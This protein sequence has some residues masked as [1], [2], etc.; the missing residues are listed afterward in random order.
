MSDAVRTL[1]TLAQMLALLL[2]LCL[3][4]VARAGG[5]L[6]LGP[7]DFAEY[8]DDRGGAHQRVEARP[9]DSPDS[10]LYDDLAGL[11]RLWIRSDESGT[12]VFARTQAA[13]ELFLLADFAAPPGTRFAIA[14]AP[15]NVG[16]A[17]LASRGGT[18][19]TPA[20]SFRDVVRL[21][22]DSRCRD[23]GLLRAWFAPGVGLVR[24]EVATPSGPLRYDLVS[25]RIGPRSFPRGERGLVVEARFPRPAVSGPVQLVLG[26]GEFEEDARDAFGRAGEGV[27]RSLPGAGTDR[28]TLGQP[29]P[30]PLWQRGEPSDLL[31]PLP[32]PATPIC[33]I[34]IGKTVSLELQVRNASR[35]PSAWSGASHQLFEITLYD[36]RGDAVSRWSRGRSFAPFPLRHSLEPGESL[37]VS[38]EVELLD[39]WGLVLPPGPYM[40]EIEIIGSGFRASAPLDL[41][42]ALMPADSPLTPSSFPPDPP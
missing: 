40:I 10:L 8:R 27:H 24:Y 30:T 5:F 15:C 29:H 19:A 26:G 35:N 13:S 4:G 42:P 36:Q 12:Q 18:V 21:D 22:F 3:A 41:L 7:G 6:P 9:L 33:A 11:G 23:A 32:C 38:G 17:Q 14:V 16:P 31:N 20:G 28:A 37:A 25:A 2:A 1:T 34:W 39:D